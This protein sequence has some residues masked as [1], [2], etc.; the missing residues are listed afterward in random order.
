[1]PAERGDAHRRFTLAVDLHKTLAHGGDGVADIGEVHR[2]AAVDDG[3]Q[4]LAV[5]AA[6]FGG[7]DQP[8]HHRRRCEHH[9]IAKL[10]AD[11]EHFVR[12]ETAGFG[13]DVPATHTDMREMIET[14][15]VRNRRC[16]Q[17]HNVRCRRVDIGEIAQRRRH[18]IAMAQ[19][20]AFWPAGGAGGVEQ[21]GE[22]VDPLRQ[23]RWRA[24]AVTHRSIGAAVHRQRLH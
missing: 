20:H 24:L 10:P 16:I 22:I 19:H 11:V 4:A 14:S 6:A 18:Q 5:L 17:R 13:N 7:I 23:R 8:P 9:D 21:P 15:A 3:A 2:P 1:M 12:I